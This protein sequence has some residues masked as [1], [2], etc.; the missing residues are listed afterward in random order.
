MS[1]NKSRTY[2]INT[3]AFFCF[4]MALTLIVLLRVFRN[5]SFLAWY[6]KYTD[7][8]LSYEIWMQTYGATWISVIFIFINYIL[9]ALIPWFPISCICVA[10]AVMFEWYYA[11]LINLAGLIILFTLKFLWGRKF[12]GGNAEKILE[13]YGAVHNFIDNSTLGSGVVLFLLRLIPCMPVNSVSCLYGTT[14]IAYVQYI[15][16]SCLGFTYK[17]LSYV[18]IGRNVFDPASASFIVPFILLFFFSGMVLLSLSGALSIKGINKNN[19]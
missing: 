13:K 15:A 10:S 17:L 5:E 4:L 18:I 1:K 11:V 9:K 12:G 2:A 6:A 14:N 7:T 19:N 8:L 3:A 16:I